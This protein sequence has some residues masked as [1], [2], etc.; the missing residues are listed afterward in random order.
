MDVK[1]CERI[2][3]LAR[4]GPA[5]VGPWRASS[6]VWVFCEFDTLS[7]LTLWSPFAIFEPWV[8][9]RLM[10]FPVCFRCTWTSRS[11]R[12]PSNHQRKYHSQM[13]A[14][15]RRRR[16]IGH[17]LRHRQ[18]G[19]EQNH[20]EQRDVISDTHAIHSPG[21]RRKTEV[22]VQSLCREPVRRGRPQFRGTGGR[23]KPVRPAG[24][25]QERSHQ[26]RDQEFCQTGVGETT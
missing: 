1:K 13:D 15:Y 22:R 5:L 7:F 10:P 2:P 16:G 21:T 14:P 3:L 26:R 4:Q 25:T 20:V 24:S 6:V 8:W 19:C 23:Q 11:D 12:V 18:K 9:R 17:E